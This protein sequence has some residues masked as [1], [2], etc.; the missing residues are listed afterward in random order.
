MYLLPVCLRTTVRPFVP[1][2]PPLSISHRPRPAGLPPAGRRQAGGGTV[3]RAEATR[4]VPREGLPPFAATRQVA[5]T[6]Q[7]A[8][9][10]RVARPGEAAAGAGAPEGAQPKDDSERGR[11]KAA[12]Q[13]RPGEAAAHDRRPAARAATRSA[14]S[15][16]RLRRHSRG[17]CADR[18][19]AQSARASRVWARCACSRL[20]PSSG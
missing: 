3:S 20:A 10:R 2:H 12:R 17:R 7:A 8:A 1:L 11:R 15:R 5:A 4:W 13:R 14:R 6:R 9:T 19:A 18:A 16:R